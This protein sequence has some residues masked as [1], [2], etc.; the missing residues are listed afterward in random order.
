MFVGITFAF[1]YAYKNEDGGIKMKLKIKFASAMLSAAIAFSVF[2]GIGVK[3]AEHIPIRLNEGK[4]EIGG[5]LINSLTYVPLEETSYELSFG[6]ADFFSSDGKYVAQSEFV[7]VSAAKDKQYIEANGRAIPAETI[8]IDGKIY[9]PIR[10]V[11]KAYDADV[12]WNDDSR[13]VDLFASEGEVIESGSSFYNGN[14]IY[15]LSRIICAEACCESHNGRVLVGNVVL[16]RVNSHEFPNDI[17][18]VIF[19][20]RYGVQFTPT[21]NGHIYKE[22]TEE[23]I[24]AA[25]L[26]LEGYSLSTEALYFLNPRLSTSFWVP[27][28]RPFL[29]SVGNHDFYS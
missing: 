23:C 9:I 1:R 10:A 6:K 27:A 11:A 2:F 3:G 16:N 29:M 8:M 14:D 22:P 28:N 19:D 4:T 17:Y 25:K 26:C 15:W 18:G 5:L 20:R 21:E 7:T 13:S 24:I 12:I